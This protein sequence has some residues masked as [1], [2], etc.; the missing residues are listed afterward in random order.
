MLISISSEQIIDGN[1]S[2]QRRFHSSPMP[3]IDSRLRQ[4]QKGA[5][6]REGRNEQ[7]SRR[8]KP[9][10]KGLKRLVSIPNRRHRHNRQVNRINETQFLDEMQNQGSETDTQNDDA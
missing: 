5:R 10:F 2:S 1:L 7:P 3:A 9:P 4:I 6:H 8:E